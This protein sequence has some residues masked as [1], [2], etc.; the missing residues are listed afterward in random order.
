MITTKIKGGKNEALVDNEGRLFTLASLIPPINPISETRIFRGYL[1]NDGLVNDGTNEN[2]LVNGSVTNQEFY[3]N[4]SPD[5]DR[6][7]DSVNFIL[8]GA[9]AELD[10]FIN[11]ARLTNG[12]EI[13]YVDPELGDVIINDSIKSNFE[14]IR[15]CSRGAPPIGDGLSAFR[16]NNISGSGGGAFEGY[17]MTLDFSDQFGIPYGVRIPKGTSLKLSVIIK[18]NLSAVTGEFNAIAYGFDRIIKDK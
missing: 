6:Y 3:I 12:V 16:A 2:M 14:F 1:T 9:G 15:L 11:I 8:A 4:S 7:I 5:G 10:E 17:F 18:D 13:K